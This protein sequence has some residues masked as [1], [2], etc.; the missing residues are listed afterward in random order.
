MNNSE[1]ITASSR[2][3]RC[4]V[5]WDSTPRPSVRGRS[6]V[7]RIAA[8]PSAL[9]GAAWPRPRSAAARPP[10]PPSPS[11]PSSSGP[12]HSVF[13]SWRAVR[14]LTRSLFRRAVR[15][16]VG[17][18]RQHR[19]EPVQTAGA[20]LLAQTRA[21]GDVESSPTAHPARKTA[22]RLY[23]TMLIASASSSS[24]P[25]AEYRAAALCSAAN[26]STLRRAR[27]RRWRSAMRAFE[28]VNFGVFAITR[29]T[30]Y[31]YTLTSGCRCCRVASVYGLAPISSFLSSHARYHTGEASKS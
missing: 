10:P 31:K 7:A 3:R 15:P 16:R 22:C 8:S 30:R 23:A 24:L 18:Q 1:A 9:S 21:R 29:V 13:L 6:A 25:G 14:P 20:G 2:P 11:P 26:F 28:S 4:A 27:K 17:V 5:V 12:D 19:L